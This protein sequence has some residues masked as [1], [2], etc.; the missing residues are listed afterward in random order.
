MILVICP[1][2][3]QQTETNIFQSLGTLNGKNFKILHDQESF[4][5]VYRF[6]LS[7]GIY[8]PNKPGINAY[9]DDVTDS[10]SSRIFSDQEL[11]NKLN[12]E[13]GGEF[14]IG[15]LSEQGKI[16]NIQMA[17]A[18]QW[19]FVIDRSL[20]RGIR[21][22]VDFLH[23]RNKLT[24]EF[25]ITVFPFD[26]EQ[27]YTT[28]GEISSKVT[29]NTI[30]IKGT[31]IYTDTRLQPY[32][33]LGFSWQWQKQSQTIVDMGKQKFD[34]PEDPPVQDYPCGSVHGGV[35]MPIISF[36]SLALN[37]QYL[38]AFQDHE[39]NIGGGGAV[40]LDLIVSLGKN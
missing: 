35:L 21:L 11:L 16:G 6:G 31:Y 1:A 36:L 13:F 5:P 23:R 4:V 26:Q 10:I 29:F 34:L 22:G 24:G 12:K 28:T 14:Y 32:I 40:S 8:L 18:F 19:G 37:L 2:I 39:K 9:D 7:C 27:P 17:P 20:G 3:G 30:G 33:G 15:E 38:M 25:P